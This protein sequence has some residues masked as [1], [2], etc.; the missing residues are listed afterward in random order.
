MKRIYI[1]SIEQR[2][3]IHS[4]GATPSLAFWGLSYHIRFSSVVKK[5][6]KWRQQFEWL[7]YA[8]HSWLQLYILGSYNRSFHLYLYNFLHFG[9]DFEDTRLYLETMRENTL[10]FFS[11]GPQCRWLTDSIKHSGGGGR[12]YLHL[13][14]HVLS[15]HNVDVNT[16]K[17]EVVPPRN[18]SFS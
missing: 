5:G 16:K 1:S 14:R 13:S 15:W 12:R 10:V 17:I 8:S 4:D 11:Y 7:T 3:K 18:L 9:K 2:L 6:N